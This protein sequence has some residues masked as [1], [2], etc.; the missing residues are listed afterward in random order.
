MKIYFLRHG[1]TEA[2]IK[3]LLSGSRDDYPLAEQ[4]KQ[5][6][7]NAG[8]QLKNKILAGEINI[9][10]IV[11]ST[12]LRARE[13]T[14]F[15]LES[16]PEDLQKKLKVIHDPR[17]IEY[18]YGFLTGKAKAD[19]NSAQI[20]T[21]LGAEDPLKLKQRVVEALNEIKNS[22]EP[23]LIVAHGGVWR[24]IRTILSGG[25]LEDFMDLPFFPNGELAEFDY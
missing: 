22:N 14:Q 23:T 20:V 25:K 2:N 15:V 9:T 6:A 16:L 4:G 1:T 3:G 18:D 19:Y 7:I 10:Q 5:D 8:L 17:L 21:C 24:M 12:M 13:T 11:S